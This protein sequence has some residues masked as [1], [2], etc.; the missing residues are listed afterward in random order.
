[1]VERARIG[2]VLALQRRVVEV[3]PD[4]EY[5]EIGIRSFGK[6]IFHKPPITGSELGNKRVFEIHPGDLV[7]SNVFAW[8]GAVAGAT[9]R[10]VGKIGSHRF[11]TYVAVDDCID[12]RWAAWF[13]VSEPGN[14]MIRKASPGSAGR[15]KTL[16]IDRFEALEIP[17]PPIDEQRRIAAK[18]D[19][20]QSLVSQ[21]S[22][23]RERTRE[24]AGAYVAG[25][26]RGHDEMRKPGWRSIELGEVL[27]LSERQRSVD[28]N[29]VYRIAGV[30]SFGGGFIDRGRLH[31][32]E[33]SYR[34]LTELQL[35]DLVVTKLNGW[36]GAVAV[37]DQRFAGAFV[38]PEYPTFH[39]DRNRLLPGFLR[40]IAKSPWFWEQLLGTTR[41]SMVRRKRV[42]PADVLSARI[43]L[44][45][46]DEQSRIA[47]AIENIERAQNRAKDADVRV[48]AIVPSLLNQVF[49]ELR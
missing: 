48:S 47:A 32:S 22:A 43:R 37:V 36:E 38:S 6:G 19:R 10:D 26:V 24:L 31:G 45:D 3:R 5:H 4:V 40:G 7:L 8:E 29:A 15:N 49:G 21:L 12:T 27:K 35:D 1:M 25:V 34:V 17:L 42:N 11:M 28:V 30:Y 46:L 20:C 41:G 14:E 44:P 2:D 39:V 23:T 33:T 13:F 18:L 9:E 16:A